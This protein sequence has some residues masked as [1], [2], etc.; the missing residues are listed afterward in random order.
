MIDAMLV[1]RK[2]ECRWP[3]TKL[4]PGA[5][6]LVLHLKDHDVAMA[7]ATS[8]MRSSYERKMSG[9]NA[10]PISP[11]FQVALLRPRCTQGSFQNNQLDQNNK[12]LELIS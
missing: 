3:E 4:M 7:I 12:Q 8:T 11:L 2:A 1:V 10:A 9:S 5:G 6:R